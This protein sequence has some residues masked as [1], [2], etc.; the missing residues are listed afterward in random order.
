M[1]LLGSASI[2]ET[3][4]TSLSPSLNFAF[5]YWGQL[6]S[7][8]ARRS[9]KISLCSLRR[10]PTFSQSGAQKWSSHTLGTLNYATDS[11]NTVWMC[12]GASH[13]RTACSGANLESTICPLNKQH[14]SSCLHVNCEYIINT[15]TLFRNT[16]FSIV[17]WSFCNPKIVQENI[18]G[19]VQIG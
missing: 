9:I 7:N 16:E 3:H 1:T 13:L 17:S 8:E 11:A 5:E 6:E 2:V 15:V 12:S 19:G 18:C 4:G 14:P 10:W